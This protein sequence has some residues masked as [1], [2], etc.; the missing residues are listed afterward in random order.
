[1]YFLM[2]QETQQREVKLAAAGERWYYAELKK[3]LVVAR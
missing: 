1:M 3:D 2:I